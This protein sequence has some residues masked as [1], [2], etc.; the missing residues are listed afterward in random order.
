MNPDWR[1]VTV[2]DIAHIKAGKNLPAD[3]RV[4]NGPVPVMGANGEIAR[5]SEPLFP[6]PVVIVG[7]VGAY[8]EVHVVDEPCLVSDNALVV[9]PEDPEQVSLPFLALLLESIDYE[10]IKGGTTQPLITQSAVNRV[11]V[12]LP[13]PREQR[14]IVDL[15]KSLDDVALAASSTLRASLSAIPSLLES[16]TVDAP[17]VAL[18]TLIEKAKAGATPSRKRPG[19]FGGQ[20]PWLKSA[21]VDNPAIASTEESITEEAL[22]ACSTWVAP[23]G[24]VVV[25]MYGATAGMVGWLTEPVAMNQAVLAIIADEKRVHGRYLY[26]WM[27]SRTAQ[28][29]ARTAGGVQ[30]NLSKDLVL[31]E[32]VSIPPI[33]VQRALAG[34]FDS[35]ITLA[36]T[37]NSE[38]REVR[39]ARHAI[40]VDMLSGDRT[41]PAAYDRLLVTA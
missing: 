3:R 34:L 27:K 26:H 1:S 12:Q 4:A 13:P 28:M 23:A 7:R 40:L 15:V 18:G 37:C 20:I 36:A 31:D 17:S 2:G 35:L 10:R 38:A 25:A 8:G 19:Y 6:H 16:A 32:P 11:Q 5:T 9:L 30:P 14:R 39:A 33:P 41:V 22:A 29:K 21:E 24:A